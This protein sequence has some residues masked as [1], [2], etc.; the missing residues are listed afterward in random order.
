MPRHGSPWKARRGLAGGAPFPGSECV[1][2]RRA[3]VPSGPAG[4]RETLRPGRASRPSA[5]F[6]GA[7]GRSKDRRRS[8]VVA[9]LGDGDGYGSI[10][11][12]SPP[13]GRSASTP[14]SAAATSPHPPVRRHLGLA[15][16]YP[17]PGLERRRAE[18]GHLLMLPGLP[19]R[20]RIFP[21]PR[22]R[23]L[24]QPGP[25]GDRPDRQR[26]DHAGRDPRI[27]IAK[28][29]EGVRLTASAA[30]PP[31][32]PASN[33][34]VVQTTAPPPETFSLSEASPGHPRHGGDAEGRL[35]PVPVNIDGFAPTLPRDGLCV[36]IT[37]RRLQGRSGRN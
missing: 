32:A 26:A 35:G 29:D 7:A 2:P 4:E 18:I 25:G 5:S 23:R 3:Q 27:A 28:T 12:A 11:V 36:A 10:S 15:R 34:T 17:R 8:L 1:S 33:A 31:P 37:P 6:S 22:P 20:G 24:P 16:R 13:L 30:P 21:I 14:A 9:D 19:C